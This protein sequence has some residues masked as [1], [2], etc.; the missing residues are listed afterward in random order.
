ML[1]SIQRVQRTSDQRDI[2]GICDDGHHD[3]SLRLHFGNGDVEESSDAFSMINL[4]S[5]LNGFGCHCGQPCS[6]KLI[7]ALCL[8][9]AL[10]DL[11]SKPNIRI[12]NETSFHLDRNQ[13]Y[14]EMTSEKNLRRVLRSELDRSLSKDNIIIVDSGNSIY[15]YRYELW[16]LMF[17]VSVG[18]LQIQQTICLPDV[19]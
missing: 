14:A 4:Y 19:L 12:I 13:T 2:D 18:L 9:E 5:T 10:N 8:S 15:G 1:V 16:T 6:G 17:A 11:E 3:R 7:G